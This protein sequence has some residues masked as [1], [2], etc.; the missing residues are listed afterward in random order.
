MFLEHGNNC[1]SLEIFKTIGIA[2]INFNSK[3]FISTNSLPPSNYE[4]I[5]CSFYK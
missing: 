1:M 5:L 4:V 3:H 2:G